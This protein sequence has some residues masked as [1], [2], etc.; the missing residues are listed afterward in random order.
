MSTSAICWS[1][2][3]Q[4]EMDRHQQLKNP[5][6]M[7]RL[8]SGSFA[9]V[10]CFTLD[11]ECTPLVFEPGKEVS[12]IYVLRIPKDALDHST[13]IRSADTESTVQFSSFVDLLVYATFSYP[14]EEPSNL[15]RHEAAKCIQNSTPC[16]AC[17][18][19]LHAQLTLLNLI[20]NKI[21]ALSTQDPEQEN[22]L[23][24]A[25][26]VEYCI[27]HRPPY[28]PAP[29]HRGSSRNSAHSTP[30]NSPAPPHRESSCNSIS[31][32]PSSR[33]PSPSP[34]HFTPIQK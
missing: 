1:H 22:L 9:L 18:Y 13:S 8:L 5:L 23:R 27:I 33:V 28:S 26:L 12:P 7:L 25:A 3:F 19:R 21:E 6:M 24:T 34:Y 10:H 30:R 31:P 29:P 2:H 17:T 4:K 15:T 20:T 14:D 11:P 16:E 32:S